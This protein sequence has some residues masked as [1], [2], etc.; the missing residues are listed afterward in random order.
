MVVTVDSMYDYE[1]NLHHR[2][3]E[4]VELF[5]YNLF[6]R[7]GIGQQYNAKGIMLLVA[8]KERK[9]R[10]QLGKAYGQKYNKRMKNY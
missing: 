4:P 3:L 7:W 10:I 9:V 1:S 5:T 6:N 2:K 8:M